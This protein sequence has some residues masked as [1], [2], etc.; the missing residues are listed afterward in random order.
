MT[1]P[2]PPAVTAD[3]YPALREF[4]RGYLHEDVAAEHGTAAAA[5]AAFLADATPEDR[6]ALRAEWR[7]FAAAIQKHTMAEVRAMLGGP[8]GARWLPARRRQLEEITQ[9]LTR[10]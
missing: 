5:A 7:L 8:L 10:R 6:E 4:C 3:A 2:V 9:A 1:R